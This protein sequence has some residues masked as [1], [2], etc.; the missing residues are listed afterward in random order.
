MRHSHLVFSD[1]FKPRR[2]FDDIEILHNEHHSSDEYCLLLSIGIRN[3][4]LFVLLLFVMSQ[5]CNKP[6]CMPIGTAHKA[7]NLKKILTKSAKL[8]VN[9]E[10]SE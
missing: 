10:P 5:I 1:R 8:S 2:L 6:L 9:V 3:S 4:E 7:S